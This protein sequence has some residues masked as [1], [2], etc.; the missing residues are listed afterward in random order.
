MPCTISIL[1][2]GAMP[3]RQR[4]KLT[5]FSA[6]L[7]AYLPR[8]A[9]RWTIPCRVW[10][11]SGDIRLRSNV[12]L[13]LLRGSRLLGSRDPMDYFHYRTDPVEPLG[14]GGDCRRAV[15]AAGNHSRR[16]GV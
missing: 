13:H 14:S 11:R 15:C 6:Q 1:E 2:T 12:T 5:P 16:D 10:F 8:A 7:T 4:C 9:A 3:V